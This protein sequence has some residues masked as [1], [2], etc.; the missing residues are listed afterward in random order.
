M[1]SF[2]SLIHKYKVRKSCVFLIALL[3]MFLNL[4]ALAQTSDNQEPSC[5]PTIN[6]E[7]KL[8]PGDG[9]GLPGDTDLRRSELDKKSCKKES[10]ESKSNGIAN[11]VIP[12]VAALLSAI[13]TFF[14]TQYTEKRNW[15]RVQKSELRS[16]QFEKITHAARSFSEMIGSVQKIAAS[17]RGFQKPTGGS[18]LVTKAVDMQV[19]SKISEWSMEVEAHQAALGFSEIELRLVG[20][21][22]H[23]HD[24]IGAA[25]TAVDSIL[26][27]LTEESYGSAVLLEAAVSEGLQQ[28]KLLGDEF[29]K[30]AEA[31]YDQHDDK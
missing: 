25:R 8:E 5:D 27:K 22:Q 23:M 26:E 17:I 4:A 30:L 9:S 6:L 31:F 20:L 13:L 16:R 11:L 7:T 2:W 18:E 15:L 21:P 24:K 19:L 29:L 12:V 28:A 10:C 3:A 1:S 14:A